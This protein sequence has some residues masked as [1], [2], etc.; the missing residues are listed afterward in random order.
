MTIMTVEKIIQAIKQ[1]RRVLR[2]TQDHLS[3]L[4]GTG[5]ATLKRF[6]SGRG[7]LSLNNLIKI[8]DILGMELKLEIKK[9]SRNEKSQGI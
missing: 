2:M 5:I 6:E 4:A 1:R 8:I 7:N 3:E 9:V